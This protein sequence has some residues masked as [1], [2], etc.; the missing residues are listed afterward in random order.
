MNNVKNVMPIILISILGLPGCFCQHEY[1]AK[2]L[3]Q[4]TSYPYVT[5]HENIDLN[6]QRLSST[7]VTSIFNSSI[8]KKLQKNK[9]EALM[10]TTKNHSNKR[11]LL[12]PDSVNLPL[13]SC[14]EIYQMLK[15]SNAGY[16]FG[17]LLTG[18]GGIAASTLYCFPFASI[19]FVIGIPIRTAQLCAST[20]AANELLERDLS[21]KMVCDELLID[22]YPV[23][24]LL[25]VPRK[26]LKQ[27][28]TLILENS[29]NPD[30]LIAFKIGLPLE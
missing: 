11:W 4:R 23:T 29:E 18:V 6:V 15:A 3:N 26:Q 5:K 22:R 8:R 19:G 16:V 24:K 12:S 14:N 21:E 25:F 27:E 9:I 13:F 2:P 10:L 1:H 28:F 17:A 30:D 7:Q 20:F